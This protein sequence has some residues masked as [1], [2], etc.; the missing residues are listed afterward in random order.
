MARSRQDHRR[1]AHSRGIEVI[2][3]DSLRYFGPRKSPK[4]MAEDIG[5]MLSDAKP[6]PGVRSSPRL[7]VR[8]RHASLRVR[9]TRARMAAARLADRAFSPISGADRIPDLGRRL[10][11]HVDGRQR[12]DRGG[13]RP[14]AT[15]VLCVYGSDEDDSACEDAKLSAFTKL[16]LDGGHHFDGK[17]RR[18]RGASPGRPAERTDGRPRGAATPAGPPAPAKLGHQLTAVH[19]ENLSGD[20]AGQAVGREEEVG[21]R[22]VLGVPAASTE[23]RPRWRRAFPARSS[24]GGSP[25]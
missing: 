22:A 13:D 25:S 4:Q 11:R 23:W 9:R 7:F 6:A 10:A 21:R 3:V 16:A 14:A 12:R 19:L 18:A 17:L 15:R 2:G 5:D 24:D 8:G 20:V 1:L